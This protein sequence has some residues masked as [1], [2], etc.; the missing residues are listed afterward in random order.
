[1]FLPTKWMSF[2][3]DLN[4]IRNRRDWPQ[5]CRQTYSLKTTCDCKTCFL[6]GGLGSLTEANNINILLHSSYICIY[7]PGQSIKAGE[8]YYLSL[9]YLWCKILSVFLLL[10]TL[11]RGLFPFTG[12]MGRSISSGR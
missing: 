2:L 6:E 5:K 12:K 4:E 7:H 3:P 11:D 8:N 10:V 1:M 9:N